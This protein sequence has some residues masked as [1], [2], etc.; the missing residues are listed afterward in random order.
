MP[1]AAIV[2]T[3]LVALLHLYILYLEMFLWTTPRGRKAFGLTPEFATATR[4]LAANQGLYNGF[5]AAGLLWGLWLGPAGDPVKIF[6]LGCVIVAGLFGAATASRRI[7][8]IQAL[9]GAIALALV[10]AG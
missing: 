4:V 1:T 5:L 10:L 9:P 8:F 3:A 7:L 2:A 6:F